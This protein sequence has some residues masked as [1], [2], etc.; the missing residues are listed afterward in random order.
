MKTHGI[1]IVGS[2]YNPIKRNGFSQEKNNNKFEQNKM[3][4]YL[5]TILHNKIKGRAETNRCINQRVKY[6]YFVA[7]KLLRVVI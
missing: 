6:T 5:I 4:I 7:S 3:S 2:P 1:A